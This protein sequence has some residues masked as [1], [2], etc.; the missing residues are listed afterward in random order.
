[1][2][3]PLLFRESFA[4][5]SDAYG[6]MI[7][8]RAEAVRQPLTPELIEDHLQGR[9]RIGA[10]LVDTEGMADQIVIDQDIPKEK[11]KD[12]GEWDR[13]RR[14]ARTIL[15]VFDDLGIEAFITS[16]KSRGL[17]VR[18]LW[19]IA[20]AAELRRIGNYVIRKAGVEAE[21]FPKQDRR[22]D[23]GLGSFVWLPLFGPDVPKGK[24]TFLGDGNGLTPLPDQW[25]ALRNVRRNSHETLAAAIAVIEEWEKENN[26]IVP[27]VAPPVPDRIP[28]GERN[29]ALTSLA[30]TMRRR[31]MSPQAIEAALLSENKARCDPSLPEK[32]VR[33]IA[34]SVSRYKPVTVPQEEPK[35]REQLFDEI[36]VDSIIPLSGFLWD[37]V[38]YFSELTD[39][40]RIFHLVLGYVSL[41]AIVGN[42]VYFSLAGDKLFPNL[43]T[44]V[45][46]PSGMSRKS[47][48]L[49]K[50]R[51]V[52]S[53]VDP[54][55]VF[56]PDFTSEALLD[57]LSSTPQGVFYHSEFRSLY[58]MLAKDYMSGAKALLTELYDSPEEYRRETKGRSVQIRQPVLSMASATT[59]NWLI[60]RNSDDDFGGGFLARFLFIPVFRRERSLPLR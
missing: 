32:D 12:P 16:S 48:S 10:Y 3:D 31:G 5:V 37:Y 51:S 7:D 20:P 42:R 26:A 45:I 1:V 41:A 53:A 49:N 34:R 57:L 33:D 8:G 2:T 52:V 58:G 14:E 19:E 50:S 59:T 35:I 55:A 30:G 11:G 56:A 36:T 46:G 4:R 29:A 40:P 15:A 25:D 18:S 43:W 60:S 44:V 21:V 28:E 17:H 9:K 13:V 24:T 38:D 23:G 27:K 6:V 39:A 47:T 54:K 22:S